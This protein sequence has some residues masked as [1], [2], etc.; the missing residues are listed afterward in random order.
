MGGEVGEWPEVEP[1]DVQLYFWMLDLTGLVVAM[2]AKQHTEHT[3]QP[4]QQTRSVVVVTVAV[5]Q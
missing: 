2:V 1:V 5:E 4:L 3:N